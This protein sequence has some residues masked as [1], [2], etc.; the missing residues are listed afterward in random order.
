MDGIAAQLCDQ[1]PWCAPSTRR[2]RLP[3]PRLNFGRFVVTRELCE[4]SVSLI[5]FSSGGLRPL[6]PWAVPVQGADSARAEHDL[7]MRQ[8]LCGRVHSHRSLEMRSKAKLRLP[9]SKMT[10][11]GKDRMGTCSPMPEMR[12]HR[13]S[14]GS[15]PADYGNRGYH[16]SKVRHVRAH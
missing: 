1:A 13:Q 7:F 16:L 14:S 15:R 12:I 6:Q 3:E 10:H 5:L 8:I 11:D 9:W 2:A 4:L